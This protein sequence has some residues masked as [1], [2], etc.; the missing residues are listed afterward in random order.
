VDGI[1]ELSAV[2]RD[3]LHGYPS[4]M[5]EHGSPQLGAPSA[6]LIDV[7]ERLTTAAS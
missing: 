3:G 5:S 6:E 4:G 1:S 7:L 2:A